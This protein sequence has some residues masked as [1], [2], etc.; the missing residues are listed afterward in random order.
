MLNVSNK[1]IQEKGVVSSSVAEAM[2][3]GVAKHFKSDYGISTT[4]NAG[5]TL[6]DKKSKIGQVFIAISGPNGV[7]SKEYMMGNHRDRV[8][9]K[10][11]NKAFEMFF[12][13]ISSD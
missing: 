2:A 3:I 10:S 11:I 4:G 12:R 7:F 6:G 9:N 13:L 1:L 8:I 5:P